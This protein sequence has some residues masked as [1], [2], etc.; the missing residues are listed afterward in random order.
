MTK[1]QELRAAYVAAYVAREAAY[2]A[3]DAARDACAARRAAYQDEL[4]KTKEP[5]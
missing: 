4:K 5:T 3:T 2:V 1:L